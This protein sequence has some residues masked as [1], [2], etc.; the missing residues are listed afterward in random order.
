[1]PVDAGPVGTVLRATTDT[2][3]VF[4]LG[5]AVPGGYS[6]YASVTE[7]VAATPTPNVA[8]TLTTRTNTIGWG[9]QPVAVSGADVEGVK[10]IA[11]LPIAISGRLTVEGRPLV[12]NDPE[13]KR[14]RVAFNRDPDP[15]GTPDSGFWTFLAANGILSVNRRLG[16]FRVSVSGIP[17]STYLKSIRMGSVDL[18]AERL[19]VADSMPTPV[20]I[21]LG[22]DGGEV[23]GSVSDAGSSRV[24]N[25]VVVVMPDAPDLRRLPHL[26]QTVNT[27]EAGSFTFPAVA[28]GTYKVFAWVYAPPN[29]WLDAEFMRPYESF[30]KTISVGTRS[31][32]DL[33]LSV[34]PRR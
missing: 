8:T 21:L 3:G 23:R 34:I 26:F 15:P 6:L 17:P 4:D 2:N 13:M 18:L 28:P 5:G 14:I 33:E 10:I 31:R 9:Y 29:S 30:G 22:A 27:D 1:V 20:E 24:A 12:E 16:E 32:Q 19:R 25:A 7:T 11:G